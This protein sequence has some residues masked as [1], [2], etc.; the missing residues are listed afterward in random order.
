MFKLTREPITV[1]EMA[2]ASAGGFV[3]FEG[4]ARD[5]HQGRQVLALEYEA[6]DE[7]AQT[8][9]DRLLVEAV[10]RF[11]VLR[12]ECIHRVG[13]LEIGETAVWIGVAAA[14]RAEAFDAC[15]W[16][17]DELKVRVPIW[18]KEHFADGD[19]GWV[20]IDVPS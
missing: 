17:I 5:H 11:G 10:E 18:K 9:G 7:M 16:I 2:V 15:E 3:S 19:S 6:F 12:A 13:R 14:H 20:G 1:P 8:E 4:K